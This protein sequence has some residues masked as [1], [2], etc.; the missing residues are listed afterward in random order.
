MIIEKIIYIKPID[1]FGKILGRKNKYL[2]LYNI[3][4][5]NDKDHVYYIVINE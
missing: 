2:V 4:M 3:Y 1:Y 5:V